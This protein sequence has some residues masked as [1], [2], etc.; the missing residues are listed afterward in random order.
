MTIEPEINDPKFF[1]TD[2][3]L[4]KVSGTPY[5]IGFAHGSIA[6]KQIHKSISNYHIIFKTR[7]NFSWKQV[8]E[9]VIKFVPILESSYPEIIQEIKGIADGANVELL[10][11][12]SLNS[13]SEI[14]RYGFSDGCTSIGQ[15][16][17][18]TKEVY[19]GQNWDW[20]SCYKDTLVAL[21]IT[22][23][24]TGKPRIFLI[25]EAGFVG[26][27]G[28][29]TSGVGLLQNAIKHTSVD[30]THWPIQ[31]AIRKALEQHTAS[32]S[33]AVLKKHGVAS[34]VSLLVADRTQTFNI[35]ATPLGIQVIKPTINEIGD[36]LITHTN[37]LL[38]PNKQVDD[39]PILNSLHRLQRVN[40]LS[41]KANVGDIRSRLSDTE[42]FPYSISRHAQ[43]GVSEYDAVITIYTTIMNLTKLEA[44]I[45]I[46]EPSTNPEQ[47]IYKLE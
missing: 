41:E 40:E 7:Y 4:V 3:P 47:Y 31:I 24:N 16:D 10:D 5:E 20:V 15:I 46:G 32:D 14:F 34:S 37:H 13:R 25:T 18:I 42:N 33:L 8:K 19:I 28:F 38:H 23:P 29:N 1:N 22:Q 12:L 21:D 6:K 9:I 45:S 36:T 2:V 17:H 26:K 30:L 27:Q 11:I 39:Q 35:E 44:N 43:E